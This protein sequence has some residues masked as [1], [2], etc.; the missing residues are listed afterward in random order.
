MRPSSATDAVDPP[1]AGVVP[2]AT[3]TRRFMEGRTDSGSTPMGGPEPPTGTEGKRSSASHGPSR[4]LVAAVALATVTVFTPAAIAGQSGPA[5]DDLPATTLP[6]SPTDIADAEPRPLIEYISQETFDDATL[7]EEGSVPAA[8]PPTLEP[9]IRPGRQILM[10]IPNGPSAKCTMNFIYQ[11][12]DDGDHPAVDDGD[13]LIGTAG[14]CVLDGGVPNSEDGSFEQ[15]TVRAC[16]FLCF[17][18]ELSSRTAQFVTMGDVLYARQNLDGTQL[19]EDYAFVKVPEDAERYIDPQT[20]VWNGP[21]GQ[22]DGLLVG[23]QLA[24]YGQGVGYGDAELD[25]RTGVTLPSIFGGSEGAFIGALPAAPGDSGGPILTHLDPVEPGEPDARAV[26]DLTHLVAGATA[27]TYS[28]HA[29]D[30][31]YEETGVQLGLVTA[32]GAFP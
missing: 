22:Q 19:G 24:T 28:Q 5:A 21:S 11:V 10:D 3:V 23:E 16:A 4:L 13:L 17:G 30:F 32:D 29:I 9:T 15:P 7:L 2:E 18:S 12:E 6:H 25:S 1:E 27:G 20:P 31:T 26:G 8:F 14:H